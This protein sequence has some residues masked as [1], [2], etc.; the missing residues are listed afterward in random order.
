MNKKSNIR[1]RFPLLNVTVNSSPLIYFDNAATTQKPKEVIDE[2]TKY[3]QEENSNIHRGVHHLSQISTDNFEE[4]RVKVQEF[5]NAEFSHEII[6]TKGTTDSINLV[7][8]CFQDQ[9]QKG[10]EVIISEME[11]HSNIVP[12]QMCCQ[13]TG[14]NLKVVQIDDRGNLDMT[15][16]KEIISN[17]TKIVAITHIS[18][19]LGTINPVKEIIQLSHDK[20]AKV[21]ID[22]AQAAAHL[23]VD[24]QDLDVDF[25]CFSAHKL[26]GPTGVGVLYGKE[27]ILNSL[28]PYQGGGEMIEK[29]ELYKSTYAPLPHKFEAGTPNIAGVIAFKKSINLIQEIGL[30]KISNYEDKLLQYATEKLLEIKGLDIIGTSEKKSAIISFN[31]KGIHHY[32]LGVLLDKMGVAIRTGHHCTQPVMA[33]F[34]VPGTARISFAY[35]NTFEEI[36]SCIIAINKAKNMLL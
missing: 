33:R 16:F 31:I 1:D 22:G 7:S 28:S 36:D 2:I 20:N 12:W 19:S 8:T 5:L 30:Q 27:K 24:V 3:Y 15:H 18:N 17:K 14:A 32:D 25:Y 9:L 21:L 26:F 35:Y 13:K 4:C 11:H 34:G 6:F 23:K 29:V 10:D